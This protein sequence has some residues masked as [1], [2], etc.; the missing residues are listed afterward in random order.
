[1]PI[2]PRGVAQPRELIKSLNSLLHVMPPAVVR[3]RFTFGND[4]S[5]DPAIFFWIT[6]SDKASNPRKLRQVT[7]AIVDTIT[8][9]IDPLNQWGL[10]PYFS[11]RSQSEQAELKEEVFE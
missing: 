8:K 9:K 6:L 10:V 2:L 1:M 7:S 4:W 3:W 11:F 5:G